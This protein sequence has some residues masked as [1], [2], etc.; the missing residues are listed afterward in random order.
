[1][2]RDSGVTL[3]PPTAP[4]E[5]WKP[6]TS[7]FHDSWF[8]LDASTTTQTLGVGADYQSKNPTAEMM[9][10]LLPR[11][12]LRD[13][14]RWNMAVRTDLRLI[15]EFTNSDTTAER[16]QWDLVDAPIWL[17]TGVILDPRVR[18]KS[19][20]ILRLPYIV[21]PISR[22]SYS[23]RR[24]W[25]LG[26]GVE[27]IQKIPA[28][29]KGSTFLPQFSLWPTLFYNYRFAGDNVAT[30][31]DTT[32]TR[33]DP[34]GQA[35]SSNQLN[36]SALPQHE[37]AASLR[38]DTYITQDLVLITQV[39][40]R[41]ARRYALNDSTPICN[42]TT[43]CVDVPLRNNASRWDVVT[44]FVAELWY[45]VSPYLNVGGGYQNQAPQLGA[46]GQ[47][48]NFF[49]S[50]E[51]RGSVAAII[52]LDTL[53]DALAGKPAAAHSTNALRPASLQ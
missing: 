51:A 35:I 11:F 32:R 16:G 45:Q 40:G 44:L 19:E 34:S 4:E 7:R 39:S 3:I 33:L 28:L 53:Y 26:A 52:V 43:G 31:S 42:V 50:P 48:R 37:V 12:Y 8:V 49:Y 15:R 29:G 13:E 30:S 47:R 1:P 20:F 22:A 46:D 2:P 24:G 10:R 18:R 14:P 23:G 27:L 36:G 9:F 38:F 21:A 6:P 25:G 17:A 41:Y 5:F